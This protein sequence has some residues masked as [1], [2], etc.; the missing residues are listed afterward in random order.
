[1]FLVGDPTDVAIRIGYDYDFSKVLKEGSE[2]FLSLN[3]SEEDWHFIKYIPNFMPVS[4]KKEGL[5][6][7]D[8]VP[9]L[10]FFYFSPPEDMSVDEL[11]LGGSVNVR[12]VLGN[13]SDA[14]L[15]NPL[16]IR[17]TDQF[18]YVIVLEPDQHR[19]VEIVEVGL[20]TNKV[21][22]VTA[23][24]EEGDQVLGP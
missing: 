9:T 13:K 2:A 23:D 11:P 20:K 7:K 17:G 12:I 10:N 24:L 8:D 1:M 21:W 19:R 4:D 16:A 3:E 22:E 5:E 6:I 15:L 18:K 14:L